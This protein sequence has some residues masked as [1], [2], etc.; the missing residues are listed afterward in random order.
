MKS[1]N[2][3]KQVH[4]SYVGD[5]AF[6]DNIM[7]SFYIIE[8]TNYCNYSCPICPNRLYQDS[9]RGYM[10]MDLFQ[11]IVN[12]IKDVAE[13][14]QLYWVGEPLLHSDIFEMISY[15]KKTTTAK[16]MLSTN[17]SLLTKEKSKKLVDSGLDKLIVSMDAADSNDIYGAIRTNGNIN[18]LNFNVISLLEYLDYLDITLQFILTNIN[19]IEKEAFIQKWSQYNVKISIQCLYTWANQLPELNNLSDYLSPMKNEKRVPCADLWYKMAIH[20]N[21]NVSRCC[22]DWSFNNVIGDLNSQTVFDIWN[23]SVIRDLRNSHKALH[24]DVLCSE[25][26]AWAT[27]QEYEYLFE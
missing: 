6:N 26:D 15:C 11:K 8:P 19:E 4:E 12:Q 5:K 3:K 22:F 1:A 25:C 7:P 24:F 9:E 20:W 16:V 21:G 13:V 18:N 27:E 10:S 14:I 2:N 23:G 17:G